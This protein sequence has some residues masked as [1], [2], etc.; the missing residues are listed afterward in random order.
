[1]DGILTDLFSAAR[2]L[3]KARGF[4]VASV[5]TLALGIGAATAVFSVVEAVLVRPLPFAEPSRV[6]WLYETS[7]TDGS[8]MSIAWPNYLDWRT[9][10]HSFD[11]IATVRPTT[12]NL[13]GGETPERLAGRQITSDFFRVLGVEPVIGRNFTDDDDRVGAPAVAIITDGFWH[14]HFGGDPHVLGRQL[15]LNGTPTTVIGVMPRGFRYNPLTNDAVYVS[16]GATATE[17]SG[18]PDRGNHNGLSGVARLKPGVTEA[19]ARRELDDVEA[20]LRREHPDTNANVTS[21]LVPVTERLVSGVG[22][23]ITTLFS[24]VGVL[25]LL[26]A[27]NVASL[28][29][30]RGVS[31]RQ[32]LAVRAALGCG[33]RRL[34]RYLLGENLIIALAGGLTGLLLASALLSALAAA[35]PPDIPRL[36]EVHIDTGVCLFAIGASIVVALLVA[37][38]PGLQATSAGDQQALVR[39]SRGDVGSASGQR[40]RRGLM[41]VEVALAVVLLTG[42]G[43]MAR[44]LHA[45]TTVDPGFD[46]THLLTLRFSIDGDRSSEE[47]IKAFDAR[48]VAFYDRLLPDVR[49]LPGVTGAASALSLPIDGSNWNS[50]FIIAGEPVPPRDSLFSAAFLPSTPGLAEVLRMPMRA[51]RFIEATDTATSPKVAVVNEEFVRRFLHGRNAVGRRF[52]QGWPE[53]DS[54]WQEIVGVIADV[55]LNGVDQNTPPQIYI[56]MAQHPTSFSALIVRASGDAAAILPGVRAAFARIMP[57]LPLYQVRTMDEMVSTAL[58]RQRLTMLILIGFAALAL[59]LAC[60]GLYGVVAHGVSARMREIGVRLALGA[61]GRQVIRLFVSQGLV[62]TLVGLAIGAGAGFSLARLVESQG[63]LFHVTARDPVAFSAAIATLLVVSLVACY[64]P[65]RRA[66]RVDPTITLRGD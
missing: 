57:T 53:Q 4:T 26:A 51:G 58:S 54:P 47:A 25:L 12:F 32:E 40:V 1:M 13:A 33:R 3:R 36:D 48:T 43:L 62:T 6:M 17:D 59:I 16:L 65:A 28:A 45:L 38:F 63:L 11:R 44:T 56:P 8:P 50:V 52:K 7:T 34:I 19:A 41:V 18:L 39:S 23:I 35:A 20:A 42:A 30:A 29:V 66:S 46:P 2:A 55:K 31:R 22:P 10:L 37:L 27:V 5:L 61:T 60:V 21:Q 49:A 24:A 15:S 64:L 14:D 9:R